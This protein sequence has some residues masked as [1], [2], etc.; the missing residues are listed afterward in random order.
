MLSDRIK[1]QFCVCLRYGYP[2]A[3]E[4]TKDTKVQS[5]FNSQLIPFSDVAVQARQ[6]TKAGTMPILCSLAGRHGYSAE[7]AELSKVRLKLPLQMSKNIC[8][9]IEHFTITSDLADSD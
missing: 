4:E 2:W 1:F 5:K 8:G 6:S 9:K 3:S 7:L